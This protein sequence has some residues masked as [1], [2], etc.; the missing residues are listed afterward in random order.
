MLI[1]DMNKD[2]NRQTQHDVKFR[3][4]LENNEL[5]A[6]SNLFAQLAPNTFLNLSGH[7]SRIDHICIK[8]GDWRERINIGLGPQ[9]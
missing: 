3:D 1:G 5:I 6:L 7:M 8:N 9:E 4:F 2:H